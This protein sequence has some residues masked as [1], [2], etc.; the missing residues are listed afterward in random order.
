MCLVK[1]NVTIFYE[2]ELRAHSLTNS[3]MKFLN[4]QL[5][6]LSGRSHPALHNI[7]TTQDAKKLR[8][9]LK[10]LT[11]D[12]LTAERQAQDQKNLDPSCKLC[13]APLESA[14]HVLVSCRATAE[15]RRRIFPEL[16][17]KVALVQPNCHLLQYHS[18][19]QLAQF[20]LD[21]T[22]FNLGDNFRIPAHNPGISDIYQISRDW[23]TA[24]SN[25]RAR[26]LRAKTAE[27]R[28]RQ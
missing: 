11:G 3:K 18:D 8:H 16:L 12:Y 19:V 20:I 10:F 22:S 28:R 5:C 21:C 7:H 13:L 1:T 6:G 23:C 2:K 9:H 14:E 17:N 24:I 4:V 15:I 26:L 27:S 25:E